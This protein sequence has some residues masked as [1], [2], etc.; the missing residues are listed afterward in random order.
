M[1]TRADLKVAEQ[2]G[3]AFHS[4]IDSGDIFFQMISH[5]NQ[6]VA[7]T[8][9]SGKILVYNTSFEAMAL[10]D[11]ASI[12]LKMVIR[13]AEAGQRSSLET[14]VS[15]ASG[16]FKVNL[17]RLNR[18]L[19]DAAWLWMF[20]R[21]ENKVGN[22]R[23][24]RLKNLYR[25]FVDN[26]FELV[27]RSSTA[28]TLAFSNR[29]FAAT[30]GYPSVHDIKGRPFIQIFSDPQDYFSI[31]QEALIEKRVTG[32]KVLFRK[33][34]GDEM[35]AIVNCL[36][37]PH[38]ESVETY[39][40]WT[41]LDI[42][43]WSDFDKR[44]QQ[45][46]EQ[47]AKANAQ[48]EKFLYSTSHDLRAPITTIFGLVNLM[49]HE[50]KDS[51]ILDY[52]DKIEASVNRLD[53][54]IHDI[55]NFSKAYYQRLS[56]VRIDF[57]SMI[58]R[59]LAK[60]VDNPS[61]SRI[62]VEIKIRGD[63]S[64]YTDTE[65]LEMI[66][67]NIIRNAVNFYDENKS[68]SFIHIYVNITEDQCVIEFIDNGIGIGKQFLEN[69]FTMFYKA[70]HLSKGAGLGLFIVKEAVTQIGGTVTVESEV[71]FGSLFRVTIPNNHKGRLINRKRQL[72]QL[73]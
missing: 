42:S 69:I 61:F 60:H 24:I 65:R 27:F 22:E 33:P 34:D 43:E 32:R 64:F 28:D 71:G 8:D 14:R 59:V 73:S 6:G 70:S 67:E 46:T 36:L 5:M 11:D 29:L 20:S 31:K 58:H 62:H 4:S 45:K 13:M 19:P 50:V 44:L 12:N 15:S 53:T 1:V 40:N 25:S 37:Y 9:A 47:L 48:V 7:I 56:S 26:M 54:I 66:M 39:F 57:E 51:S 21:M 23:L 18:P 52:V 17:I 72:R 30:F 63:F 3:K 2:A 10:R 68:R 38:D 49:R 16:M 41:I 55:L 35:L